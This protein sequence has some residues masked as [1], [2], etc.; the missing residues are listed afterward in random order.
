MGVLKG[1][2]IA[3]LSLLLFLSLAIF[4]IALTL[5]STVLNPDFVASEVEKIDISATV[6]ELTEE[7]ITE[8]LPEEVMFLKEAMYDF[9]AEEEPWIK[10]QANTIIHSGYDFLLENSDGFDVVIPLEPVKEDLREAMWEAF[11]E[12]IPRELA[13]LPLALVKPYFDGYSQELVEVIPSELAFDESLISS[14]VMAQITE[15]RDYIGYARTAYYYGL[16]AFMVVL[17][18]GIILIKRNVRGA[19]RGLGITFLV[20]GVLQLA[21]VLAL[22]N[23]V[24][25]VSIPSEI[26][27]SLQPWLTGLFHD[28]TSPLQLFSIVILVIGAVMLAFS[29][30]YRRERVEKEVEVNNLP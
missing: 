21:S 1:F 15:A 6:R 9:I 28:F 2:G 11:Q 30:F 16:I 5:Q 25:G 4:G 14:E 24:A 23:L 22:K 26:P 27:L 19:T 7:E 17:I 3:I 13:G 10:E 20:Y 12:N 29:F 8:E 18:A